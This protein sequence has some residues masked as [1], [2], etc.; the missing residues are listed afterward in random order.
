CRRECP[1]GVDMAKMKVEVLAAARAQRGLTLR[2]RFVAH[3]PRYAPHA[4]W[5]APLMNLRNRSESLAD[6]VQ[7]TVGF[8][9]RRK[10]PTWRTDTFKRRNRSDQPSGHA[11]STSIAILADTFNATFEPENLEAACELLSRLG[12]RVRI[13]GAEQSRSLC[14]GR[15]YLSAGMVPEAKAEAKRL[16]DAA[17][18]H[19]ETGGAIVGLEPSCLLTMRDEFLQYGFGE[20]AHRI[21]ENAFLLEEFLVRERTAGHLTGAIGRLESTVHVHTHC[22]QKAFGADGA[23]ADALRLVEGLDVK[24]MASSCCGMA[25]AFGYQ[26]E[27]YDVSMAMGELTLFPAVRAAGEADLVAAD[28]FSCRHQIADGT[29]RQPIHV[30]RILRDAAALTP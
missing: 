2:D 5:L 22:H 11:K 24:V 19:V 18:A 26:A 17:R 3:L 12:Y 23:V 10:L 21:G 20:A 15:T 8:A 4:R 28:G 14:C 27:T 30:A 1:T 13:L 9:S 29:G 16:F 25:G 6:L 7:V